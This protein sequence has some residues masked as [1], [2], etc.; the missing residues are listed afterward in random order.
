[1]T[2]R[3]HAFTCGWLTG[4]L[5][6]FLAGEEGTLRVPVPCF[7][8]EHPEGVV[9]FDSG[10]HP[11]IQTDPEGRLGWLAHLFASEFQ[12][13]EEVSARLT[14]VGI[15]PAAVRFLVN[16]HLHFDHTGGN[17]LIPNARLVVQRREWQAG[18][19]PDLRQ[20]NAF[21]P[22]DFDHGHDVVQIDGEHDLFGDGQVVCL[23]TYGHTPGHQSL[24]V[25]VGQRDIILASDACYL[26]R[27]LEELHL[28]SVVHDAE[29]MRASLL[30][31]RRLQQQGAEIFY[32]HDPEFWATV[33]ALISSS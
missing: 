21:D 22:K 4:Q 33:P 5:S 27:T 18:Q 17:Q 11:Q 13:G 25:R 1:M 10:L 2:L 19:D 9:L 7:A 28:P 29:T 16:S 31:L 14:A 12:A 26:R 32:G 3:L 20:S 15:D 24:R 8:I 6:G 23:P 30:T